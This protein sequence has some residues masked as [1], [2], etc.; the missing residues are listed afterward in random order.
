[1]AHQNLWDAAKAMITEKLKALNTCIG[2]EERSQISNLAFCL[3]K[4]RKEE[5]NAKQEE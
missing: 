1:M 4:L 5:L 2:S 3:K